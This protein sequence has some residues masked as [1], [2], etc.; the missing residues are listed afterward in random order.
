MMGSFGPVVALSS[1]SN[2]LNQTLASGE[3]VLSLLEEEPLVKEIPEDGSQWNGA[4]HF[5][6]ARAEHVTFSYDEEVILNDYSVDM[7]PGQMIGIHGVSG[8]GKS[9]LLKLL[10]RFLGG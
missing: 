5:T 3:R 8:S 1:L 10:M 2:N 7:Q 6:G 4:E 9:T